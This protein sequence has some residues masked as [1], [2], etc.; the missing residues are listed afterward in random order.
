M[1]K[2]RTAFKEKM[3]RSTCPNSCL[4]RAL[5]A[6]CPETQVIARMQRTLH[7]LISSLLVLEPLVS[8]VSPE[9]TRVHLRLWSQRRLLYP[10]E[11]NS[12]A[13]GTSLL[14]SPAGQ[15]AYP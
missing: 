7:L 10:A 2:P 5:V 4:N 6:F 1:V 11:P 14:C 15:R 12:G 13:R 8:L 9:N 3:G